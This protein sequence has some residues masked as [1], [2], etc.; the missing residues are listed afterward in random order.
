M[1]GGGMFGPFINSYKEEIKKTKFFLDTMENFIEESEK[2]E[3]SQLEVGIVNLSEAERDEYWQWHYP[4]HWQEI[5]SNRI[6]SSFLLQICTFVEGELKEICNRVASIGD[7]PIK[8]SELKGSTLTRPKKYLGAFANFD[9]PSSSCWKSMEFIF[10][11]RNVMVHEAGFAGYYKNY[12]SIKNFAKDLQ[13]IS[14]EY[15]CIEVDKVFC[16]YSLKEVEMFCK[17][18]HE[19]YEAFR[20]TKL[21][22]YNL[23]NRNVV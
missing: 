3:V 23:E 6:R 10:D 1:T 20:L 13:G 7:V 21:T 16:E 19:A 22:L 17:E 5:F 11:I 14:F 8:V 4:I 18:L 15:D 12:N 2:N 9:K